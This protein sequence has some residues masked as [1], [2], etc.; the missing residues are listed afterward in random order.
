MINVIDILHECHSCYFAC[1]A[2]EKSAGLLCV[3]AYH[4]KSIVKL[5]EY[6]FDTFSK[7]LVSPCR[8]FP[9]LLIQPIRD[10]Q[11]NVSDI[12]EIPLYLCVEIAFISEHRAV[13][14]FPLHILEV[15]EVV[16]T[17]RR[18]VVR[19]YNTSYSTDSVEF[20]AIIIH[21]LRGAVAPVWCCVWIVMPH[22][23][24][25]CPGILTDL[26]GFRVDA[27]YIF[28]TV[29]C[30]C[31]ITADILCK[32]CRQ[33]TTG[34]KLPAANQVWQ[35]LFALMVQAIKKVIFTVKVERL[36]CY[37]KSDDFQVG[38]LGNGSTTRYIPKVVYTISGEIL[39]NSKYSDE[40]CY[41][42]AHKQRNSS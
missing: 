35:I 3:I 16:D 41:E 10:F 9:V 38:K 28:R 1:H 31:H 19:M 23:A 24:A 42:V 27:K 8:L 32:P 25:V 29:Y 2:C 20:I 4:H 21:S 5:G 22:G 26:D 6:G 14:I 34:I 37:A 7:P 33:L 39:A 40:I 18:Q 17:C 15:M 12:K 13:M 30:H 11:S 36:G